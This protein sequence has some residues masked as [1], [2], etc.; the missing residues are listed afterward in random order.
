VAEMFRRI[1]NAMR[2]I[3]GERADSP[4][5]PEDNPERLSFLVAAVIEMDAPAKQELLEM[6][7]TSRR[8]GR[9]YSLLSQAVEN[10]EA[11]ARV[12]EV[13]KGNGHARRAGLDIEE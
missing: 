3:S 13:S 7:S 1:T 12:H 8:L 5:L 2:T 6:R 10:Y 4:E 9:L 11:R